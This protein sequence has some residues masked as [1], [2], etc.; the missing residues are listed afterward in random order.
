MVGLDIAF[1]YQLRIRYDNKYVRK[2]C[3]DDGN[4]ET[5]VTVAQ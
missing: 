5:R 3:I 4:I 2:L 1:K